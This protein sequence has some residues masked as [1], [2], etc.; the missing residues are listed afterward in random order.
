MKGI[1]KQKE[2]DD[3][4]PR[5]RIPYPNIFISLHSI[6]QKNKFQFQNIIPK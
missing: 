2:Y 1:I 6:W 5:R 3:I 4:S